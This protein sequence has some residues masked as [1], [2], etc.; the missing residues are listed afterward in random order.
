[1]GCLLGKPVEGV[2]TNVLWPF[3]QATG[4][5]PLRRY[6]SF[7]V[8][9]RVA[10][11]FGSLVTP[12]RRAMDRIDHMPVDDDTNYTLTGLL[13]LERHGAGFA[14]AD[15]ANFWLGNI[16][17][18][19]TC[20]AERVAYRNLAMQ[21]QPPASATYRNPYREWIGA[22]IR[23]DAF[24]YA[25]LGNPQKAADFAWRDACISHVKNGIYGEMWV[26]A[27]LAAAPFAR[28]MVDL[29]H[30]GLAEIPA[31]S[32]LYRDVAEIVECYE[33]EVPYE[34]AVAHVHKKWD[35]HLAHD[36]CHTNSNAAIVALGL[37]YGEEDFG[38]SICRAVQPCFDTD[39][40]GATVGSIVGMRLG[41]RA[42]PATW[43]GRLHDTL[44]TSLMNHGIVKISDLSERTYQVFRKVSGHA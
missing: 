41:A 30:V 27:M 18:L 21:M 35:E 15:V 1:V 44:H 37:L 16:P 7:D 20:T 19:S 13:I 32:R 12:W 6:I 3:L 42:L 22:Q 31:T 24:G 17:L 26:A 10:S 29:V 34:D 9:R 14:P 5:W 23:A 43:T 38:R 25:A 8:P 2:R 4:Q 11:R 39:C 40:N 36:W 28:D 33:A